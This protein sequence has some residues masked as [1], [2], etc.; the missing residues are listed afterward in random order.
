[1]PVFTSEP[2]VCPYVVSRV[3]RLRAFGLRWLCRYAPEEPGSPRKIAG[4]RALCG[5]RYARTRLEQARQNK[6]LEMREEMTCLKNFAKR[7]T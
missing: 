7:R 6:K 4:R 3:M 2:P 5:G 1:M